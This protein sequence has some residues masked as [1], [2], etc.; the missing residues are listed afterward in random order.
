MFHVVLKSRGGTDGKA[1]PSPFLI[2]SSLCLSVLC[3]LPFCF[4]LF[5]LLHSRTVQE[6]SERTERFVKFLTDPHLLRLQLGDAFFRR[7]ILTQF[8]ILLR[9]LRSVQ[10]PEEAFG[11]VRTFPPEIERELAKKIQEASMRT[12][13]LKTLSTST[14]GQRLLKLTWSHIFRFLACFCD[15]KK[16][17]PL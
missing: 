17:R 10:K 16:N 12:L 6:S 7:H 9:H 1:I 11:N 13:S 8:L 15:R 4:S 5:C 14:R 2:L 3:S